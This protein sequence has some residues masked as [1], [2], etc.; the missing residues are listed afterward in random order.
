MQNAHHY[1]PKIY[2]DM[3]ISCPPTHKTCIMMYLLHTVTFVVW[4][5]HGNKKLKITCWSHANKII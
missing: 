4:N 5:T 2:H 3:Y 1:A